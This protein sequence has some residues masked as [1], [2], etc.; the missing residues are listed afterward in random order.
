MFSGLYFYE[1]V[2]LSL[3]VTLFIVLTLIVVVKVFRGESVGGMVT[4]FIVPILF[5][6]FPS[7]KAIQYKD[8]VLSVQMMTHDLQQQ[9]TDLH[10][11]DTLEK[12]LRNVSPRAMSALGDGNS[13]AVVASA[14]YALGKESEAKANLRSALAAKASSN[15]A[16][17]LKQKIDAVDEIERLTPVVTAHPENK[18]LASELQVS[19]QRA[20]FLGLANPHALLRVASGQKAL[21]QPDQAASTE[22]KVRAIRTSSATAPKLS[23]EPLVAIQRPKGGGSHPPNA[24]R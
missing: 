13:L 7:I 11:R 4:F 20:T 12:A 17:E 16:V 15:I 9:P 18:E 2:L 6:G 21:G 19:V 23:N 5:I 3:G 24:R 14:Q 8:G 22:G 1:I 10:L